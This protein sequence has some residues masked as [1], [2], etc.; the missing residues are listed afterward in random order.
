[1]AEI[2]SKRR[3]PTPTILHCICFACGITFTRHAWR[4]AGKHTFCSTKCSAPLAVKTRKMKPPAQR[5]FEG[6]VKTPTCWIWT[7][8]TREGYG[9]I[10]VNGAQISTHRFSWELHHGPVPIGMCV[11]HKCDNRPCV[12]PDH[13]FLGTKK[14]NAV[15][16][17][18]KGRNFVSPNFLKGRKPKFPEAVEHEICQRRR[19]GESPTH[20]GR[21]YGIHRSAITGMLRR[22]PI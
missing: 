18:R 17:G 5:F 12:N 22:H 1:L 8:S 20:L 10:F 7:R 11:L 2:H 4:V 13:L 15:D 14:D 9:L 16:M 6:V 3:G 21:E 19:N